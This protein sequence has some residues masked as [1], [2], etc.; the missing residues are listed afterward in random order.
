MAGLP[1]EAGQ[2]LATT[3]IYG[4]VAQQTTVSGIN[5]A[6]VVATGIAVVA[7]ILAFFIKRSRPATK[8]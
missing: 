4:K 8:K 1:S 5:D 6:F 2:T 7:L 3:V